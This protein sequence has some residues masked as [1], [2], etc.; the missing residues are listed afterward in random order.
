MFVEKLNGIF[1]T[2]ITLGQDVHGKGSAAALVE[3]DG[4]ATARTQL[5]ELLVR[6]LCG[7]GE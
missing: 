6:T 2:V 4:L 3:E 5:T 1:A 7:D